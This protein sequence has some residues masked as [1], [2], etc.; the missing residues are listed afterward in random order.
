M[1]YQK[2][3]ETIF[4]AIMNLPP[5]KKRFP[6]NTSMEKMNKRSKFFESYNALQYTVNFT[7][8]S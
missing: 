2:K 8:V 3:H 4:N 6:K 5:G 7:F 1:S